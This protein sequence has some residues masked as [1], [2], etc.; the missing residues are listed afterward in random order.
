MHVSDCRD[1]TVTLSA[2]GQP[3]YT[4]EKA[5]VSTTSG[6]AIVSK[7][8]L[9]QDSV[10]EA[11]DLLPQLVDKCR[12]MEPA[13]RVPGMPQYRLRFMVTISKALDSWPTAVVLRLAETST[14]GGPHNRSA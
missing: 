2:K 6:L 1:F 5:A 14:A 13:L 8:K 12:D 7:I 11:C 3:D 10:A 4:I 9:D